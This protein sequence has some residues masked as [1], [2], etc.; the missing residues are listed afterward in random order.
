MPWFPEAMPDGKLAKAFVDEWSKR[1]HP[2][3]GLTE[4]FR[5]HDGI[6]TLA[7]A[8]RLA[9]AVDPKAIRDALWKV[10]FI[11]L[12]GP[13]RF[14][15]EGPVGRESGQS[16]SSVFLVQIRNGRV[17]L[18]AFGVPESAPVV[19]A[20]VTAALPRPITSVAPAPTPLSSQDPGLQRLS[21][22]RYHALIIAN[23]A[24]RHLPRLRTP[25][26]D[27]RA[28][29]QILRQDY[30]F[31]GLRTLAD[32]TRTDIVRALDDLRRT[33]NEK[34]NLLIYYAGHGYLDIESDR[35]Y[36]L[37]IDSELDGR[38]NWL[39][40]ADITDALK[41]LKAKHVLVVA[42]SCYSG[43]LTRSVDIRPLASPDLIRLAEK[44]ARTV[45]TSGALEPVL[46]VGGGGH[47]VFAKAF[48]D[49]LR[50]NGGI[51]EAARLHLEI[52]RQVMLNAYQAPQYADIRLAG[53][54]GG[55]FL[56]VRQK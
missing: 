53:H 51:T 10:N 42:D 24:Y 15:K 37:P 27:A 28:L 9:G 19:A 18:P 43:T 26:A 52:R 34:D 20:P 8:I 5:G 32:A 23:E 6:A 47:S 7:E 54:E 49:A 36:W 33:L 14:E 45:L 41:A 30:R 44:R 31:D 11:G 55:D 46:D 13:I 4:G 29:A 1:G 56:F 17:N 12:N 39:S 50:S 35:G 25:I 16:R 22:G 48:L 2:F 40:N 3:E 21:T 38:A